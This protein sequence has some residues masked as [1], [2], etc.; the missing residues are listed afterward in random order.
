MLIG[1]VIVIIAVAT[2]VFIKKSKVNETPV[3]VKEVETLATE[4]VK[5]PAKKA[6]KKVVE[7]ENTTKVKKTA[8]KQK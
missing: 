5:K 2:V 4:E 1:I 3:E 6:P 8:K 7:V